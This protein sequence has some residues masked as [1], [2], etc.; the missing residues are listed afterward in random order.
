MLIQVISITK[1]SEANK[2]IIFIN[3]EDACLIQFNNIQMG[4]EKVKNNVDWTLINDSLILC[5][6]VIMWIKKYVD[7][8][9]TTCTPLPLFERTHD[10]HGQHY[11][12]CSREE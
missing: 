5:I 9:I 8:F 7:F 2:N 4:K 3:Q 6:T 10:K 11:I 1:T 12:D